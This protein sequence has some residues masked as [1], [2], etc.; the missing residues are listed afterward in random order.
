[1]YDRLTPR[2]QKRDTRSGFGDALLACAREEARVVA[3]CADLKDSLKM[4]AMSA[5]FPDRY[6]ACGIAEANMVGMAAGLA[7]QGLR[8]VVGTFAAFA[9]GRVYDQIRQS[10]AYSNLPVVIAASHAGVTLGE[11]GATHQM[12]EDVGMMRAL[13]NMTV[14]CPCDYT[15]TAALT[16]LAL[17][18]DGPVYLRFGRPKVVDFMPEDM[19]TRIGEAQTLHE[20]SDVTIVAYGHLVWPALEAAYALDKVGIGARV[21][22][23]HTIKPLDTEAIR[24]AALETGGIV[25]AEEHMRAGGLGEAIAGVVTESSPVPMRFIAVNDQ[26]GQSG[27]PEELLD[28][29]GLNQKTIIE[30]VKGLLGR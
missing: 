26:F 2:A 20:G 22:N 12:L 7:L 23:M 9:T 10:V 28:L 25:V 24:R 5:E 3:L 8:P 15:Q 6:L 29:Y 14:L 27:T 16:R 13:P 17:Q 19:P 11:D 21:L 30:S 4:G 18:V 1:M